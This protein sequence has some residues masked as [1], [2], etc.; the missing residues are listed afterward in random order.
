MPQ[1]NKM[2]LLTTKQLSKS[3]PNTRLCPIQQISQ[4]SGGPVD[5]RHVSCHHR[6]HDGSA[7]HTAAYLMHTGDMAV[8]EH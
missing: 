5:G 7:P 2:F 6:A 8:P 4:Y 1:C 3:N